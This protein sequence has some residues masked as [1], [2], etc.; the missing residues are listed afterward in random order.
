MQLSK[1]R[2]AVTRIRETFLLLVALVLASASAF[3]QGTYTQINV[4]GASQ[5]RCLGIDSVGD[6]VG[7]SSTTGGSI[8]GF[9]LSEG[10]YTTINYHGLDTTLWGINDK[11]QIVG[12]SGGSFVY[13]LN[14]QIFFGIKYPGTDEPTY[15]YSINNAGVVSGDFLY[16]GA[17]KG[18]ELSGSTYSVVAPPGGINTYALGI[19][20]SGKI[21]GYADTHARGF[22]D[23]WYLQGKYQELVVPNASDAFVYGV[24]P[25]GNSLVGIYAP[26]AGTGAGFA[27]VDQTLQTLLFPGAM[28]T[29]PIGIN[30][31]GEVVGYFYDTSGNTHGFTWTPPAAAK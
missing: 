13:N 30:D 26:S 20:G 21:V 29:I 25:A 10:I 15:A 3:A 31:T 22:I 17:Y 19:T 12:Q 16:H 27:Y 8:N 7:Y 14:T 11:G 6:V 2:C 1:R 24:S 4:P 9:L 28:E 18:F 23:F 5:T